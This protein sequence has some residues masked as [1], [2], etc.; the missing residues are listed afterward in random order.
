MVTA[1]AFPAGARAAPMP[2]VF[3][4]TDTTITY[5]SGPTGAGAPAGLGN[6][7][8]TLHVSAADGLQR[9]DAPGGGMAVITDTVHGTMIVLNEAAHTYVQ[10][11]APPGTADMRGKRAPGDYARVGAAVVAGLPCTEWLTHDPSAH[12]VTV[13][14]TADGVLLRVRADGAVLVQAA[15][16]S[17]AP[18][19]P[20]LFSAP[21]GWRRV[22]R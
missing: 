11:D 19:D 2:F 20:A 12:A 6:V 10:G 5:V 15:S 9:V 22:A 17:H 4:Q 13:C 8:Q 16:V 18:Q 1:L 3:P 7:T 14:L 21:Q